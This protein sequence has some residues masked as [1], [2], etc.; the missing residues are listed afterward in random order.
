MSN[1]NGAAVMLDAHSGEILLMASHPTYDPNQLEAL[2]SAL[3]K[4][5][6]APLLDRAT[7]GAYPAGEAVV[8]FAAASGIGPAPAEK[9]DLFQQ[10]GFYA[11]PIIRMPVANASTEGPTNTM[12]VSPLQMAIAAAALSNAGVRPTPRI[13]LAVDTPQ[14]GWVVLPALGSD[15]A[16]FSPQSASQTVFA[17]AKPGR[18]Y[19]EWS[20]SGRDEQGMVSWYLAGTLP[21]WQ[22]ARLF[23]LS[24]CSNPVTCLGLNVSVRRYSKM[25][26]THE[27]LGRGLRGNET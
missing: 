9:I 1:S 18:A 3:A 21:S 16:V 8:P 10:L 15:S 25:P 6:A 22:A 4:D 2:G 17:F 19:W 11:E 7:L 5:P 23:H 12:R 20:A 26:S 27:S 14:Q 13:A 24:C